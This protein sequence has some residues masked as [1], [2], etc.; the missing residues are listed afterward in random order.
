MRDRILID[1]L[2]TDMTTT[3]IV[4]FVRWWN[5][6]HGK[7]QACWLDGDAYAIVCGRHQVQTVRG[8]VETTTIGRVRD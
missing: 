5:S 3:E 2:H 4:N 1:V 7:E 6:W 8:I